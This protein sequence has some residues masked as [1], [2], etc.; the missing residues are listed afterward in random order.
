MDYTLTAIVS[1]SAIVLLLAI[2]VRLT[3]KNNIDD[4]NAQYQKELNKLN[5][6]IRDI[7]DDISHCASMGFGNLVVGALLSE[8]KKLLFRLQPIDLTKKTET[9][10]QHIDDA[11]NEIKKNPTFTK[12]KSVTDTKIIPRLIKDIKRYRKKMSMA[13]SRGD[14]SVCD[15]TKDIETIDEL[16]TTLSCFYY[17]KKLKEMNDKNEFQALIIVGQLETFFADKEFK[18]KERFQVAFDKEAK[19]SRELFKS[20]DGD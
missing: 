14:I 7:E 8:K 5:P 9:E 16:E 18:M 1:V 12:V 6:L 11:L 15:A 10:I 2:H 4:I 20:G 13:Y 17:I 3:K 19:R